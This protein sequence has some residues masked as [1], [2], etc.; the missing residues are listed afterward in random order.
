MPVLNNLLENRE[1]ALED[2]RFLVSAKRYDKLIAEQNYTKEQLDDL[3]VEPN[4][5]QQPTNT[6]MQYCLFEFASVLTSTYLSSIVG[7]GV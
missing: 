1:M 4:M 6:T 5:R 3:K 7:E 2:G